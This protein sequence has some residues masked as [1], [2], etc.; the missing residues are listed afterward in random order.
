MQKQN[1]VHQLRQQQQRQRQ[2]RQQLLQQLNYPLPN[3]DPATTK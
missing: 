3:F 1:H 2:Q